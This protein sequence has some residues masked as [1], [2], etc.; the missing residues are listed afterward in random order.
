MKP[1]NKH[2]QDKM[3][4]DAD[5]PEQKQEQMAE[6]RE[7]PKRNERQT[8]PLRF[9]LSM[10]DMETLG[11]IMG[12]IEIAD[13]KIKNAQQLAQ[14]AQMRKSEWIRAQLMQRNL[15]IE[16]NVNFDPSNGVMTVQVPQ[17]QKQEEGK[18]D[19]EPQANP[20]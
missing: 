1:G 4:S 18:P 17:P 15:P 6:V 13:E 2:K 14:I 9:Q 8:P 10:N 20:K 11:I 16:S 5:S 7:L 12:R 3:P 19:A